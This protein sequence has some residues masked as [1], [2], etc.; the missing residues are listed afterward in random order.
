VVEELE[1]S[2]IQDFEVVE[3]PHGNLILRFRIGKGS[4]GLTDM[5][6]ILPKLTVRNQWELS[7]QVTSGVAHHLA[8]SSTGAT[9][10]AGACVLTLIFDL[11][12]DLE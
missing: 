6:E 4:G 7:C 12:V 1:L 3:H 9:A 11:G 2:D 5:V 8:S 10:L